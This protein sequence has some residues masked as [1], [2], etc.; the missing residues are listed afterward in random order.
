MDALQQG[1]MRAYTQILVRLDRVEDGNLGDWGPVGDGV[2]ELRF[3]RT[4]TGYRLYIGLEGDDV[5]ILYGGTKK[6][7]TSD[8]KLARKLWREYKN[9]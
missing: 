8:I 3:M 7:Q 9:G 5:V 1:D 4:G 6:T 2:V